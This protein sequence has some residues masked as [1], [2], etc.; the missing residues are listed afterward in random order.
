MKEQSRKADGIR[1]RI[2]ARLGKLQVQA[3]EAASLATE[4]DPASEAVADLLTAI[5]D[6]LA[7]VR[8]RIGDLL[9]ARATEPANEETDR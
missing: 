8:D 1:R 6:D 7:I 3:H 5:E 4:H 9:H 2:I